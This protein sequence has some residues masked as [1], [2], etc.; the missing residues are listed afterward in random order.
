MPAWAIFT[1]LTGILVALLLIF[2]RSSNRML[3]RATIVSERGAIPS[4]VES[5]PRNQTPGDTGSPEESSSGSQPATNSSTREAA[6]NGSSGSG[7][8]PPVNGHNHDPAGD[9]PAEQHADTESA[10]RP[11]TTLSPESAVASENATAHPESSGVDRQTESETGPYLT[12]RALQ[13]NVLVSQGLLLGLL[14]ALT[15]WAEV[16]ATAVGLEASARTAGTLASGLAAGLAL[17]VGNELAGKIA[18]RLGVNAPI[19]LREALA[20]ASARGWA[21]LLLVILPLIAVFEEFLFRGVLIGAFAAGFDVSPW[22]LVVASSLVFGLGHGAQGRAGILV[23]GLLGLV[24]GSVFVVSGS[25][26]LVIVAHYVVNAL[27]FGVHEGI[28]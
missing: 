7:E 28:G 27:E 16:P 1:A 10:G 23:S 3:D 13:V 11:G 5:L 17:Y 19:Q 9:P 8:E 24:L 12:T 2:S 18:S 4:H 26:T 20:P 22:V 25:L 14:V 21:V 6:D 15:W